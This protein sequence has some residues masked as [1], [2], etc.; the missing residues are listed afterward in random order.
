[1]DPAFAIYGVLFL[2]VTTLVGGLYLV[3]FGATIRSHRRQARRLAALEGGQARPEVI[4]GLRKAA[5]GAGPMLRVPVLATFEGRLRRAGVALAPRQAVA[6]MAAIAAAS[7]LG[8]MVATEAALMLRAV[9]A[10]A[11]GPGAVMAW[12]GRRAEA[13]QAAIEE[14]LPDAI[15]LM[16]RSIR[17]GHPLVSAVQIVARQTQGPLAHEMAMV[18]DET[19]YG[20][21]MGEALHEMAERVG[22]QDLRFLAMAVTIQ[23][24]SGGNLAEVLDGL[25]KVIRSRFRLFRRVKAITAEAKWSGMFLSGFPVVATLGIN[26]LK[27]DYFDAVRETP[28]F[29][30]AAALVLLFLV[31]NV[32]VMRRLVDI[33][34]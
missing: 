7:F 18:A 19:A 29:M 20:R 8:L 12:V 4:E 27:P 25:A 28:Y 3:V 6:L 5:S 14:A 10:A 23:S 31:A 22:V 17:V 30:P 1:M 32:L 16:V 13:R 2:A 15:E 34:V 11:I 21:D 33:E 26:L 24:Q 9:L